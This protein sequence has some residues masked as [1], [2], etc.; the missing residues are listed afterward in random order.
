M[1]SVRERAGTDLRFPG[2]W[3]QAETALIQNWHRDYDPSLGR[4]IQADPLGLAAGQS[5]YGYA[6]GDPVNYVDPDGLIA[7]AGF[8]GGQFLSAGRLGAF[9]L[10]AAGLAYGANELFAPINEAL[11]RSNIA[12]LARGFC[13]LPRYPFNEPQEVLPTLFDDSGYTLPWETD[14]LPDCLDAANGSADD[15]HNFCGSLDRSVDRARCYG[16]GLSTPTAKENWC[17]N[18]FGL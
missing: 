4:Y 13:P 14:P 18:E 5:I 1:Y 8:G 16:E 12:D 6:L 15:W 2:Q 7:A 3:A 17:Y 9:G 11:T 10:A